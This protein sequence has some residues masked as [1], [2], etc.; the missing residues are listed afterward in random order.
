[1]NRWAVTDPLVFFGAGSALLMYL[2]YMMIRKRKG[3][4]AGARERETEL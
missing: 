2:L 4:R 3:E 1:M